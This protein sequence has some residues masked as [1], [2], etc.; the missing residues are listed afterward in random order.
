MGINMK[1]LSEYLQQMESVEDFVH[2]G[3]RLLNAACKKTT[4]MNFLMSI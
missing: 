3:K 2:A 4:I 1:G